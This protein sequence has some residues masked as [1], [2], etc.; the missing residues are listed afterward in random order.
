M[1][2]PH[3]KRNTM[4]PPGQVGDNNTAKIISHPRR[5]SGLR[6]KRQVLESELAQ[7]KLAA[8]I[9]IKD[10]ISVVAAMRTGDNAFEADLMTEALR[11]A[12]EELEVLDPLHVADPEIFVRRADQLRQV[13]AK[14]IF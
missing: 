2:D 10:A 12:R 9:K 8:I 4:T 6:A 14:F 13:S 11:L 1:P 7:N 3:L 5:Q